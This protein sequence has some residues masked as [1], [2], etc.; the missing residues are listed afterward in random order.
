MIL[1]AA[2]V[3]GVPTPALACQDMTDEGVR[4]YQDAEVRGVVTV[5]GPTSAFLIPDSVRRGVR[6]ERYEITWTLRPTGGPPQWLELCN[7]WA[8]TEPMVRGTFHLQRKTRR[9][10]VYIVLA[11]ETDQSQ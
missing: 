8:P 7:E 5:T 3:A 9:G 2:C 1:V 10:P 4:M 11:A 6:R